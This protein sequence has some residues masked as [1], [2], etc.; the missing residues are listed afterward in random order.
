MNN[1]LLSFLVA[2]GYL[3]AHSLQL[4]GAGMFAQAYR[5]ETDDG[6]FV[7]RIGVTREAFKKDQL[8]YERLGS[9][10][11]IPKIV[12]IGDYDQ[13]QSYCLSEYKSGR[14]LTALSKA[15]TEQLLP[16]LFDT[17]LAMS[18]ISLSADT[19]FGILNG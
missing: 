8:A 10:A 18:R 11:P 17:I 15:E 16:S 2:R 13:T 6:I 3:S 7:L 12:M 9:V 5:F 19:G 14:I 4:L 1:P